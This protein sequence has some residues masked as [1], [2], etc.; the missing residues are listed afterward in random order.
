M[1]L[2][3]V[4][5]CSAPATWGR[6]MPRGW[7]RRASMY[8]GWK[9]TRG[10]GG[11]SAGGGRPAEGGA[12]RPRGSPLPRAGTRAAAALRPEV[13]TAFLHHVLRGGGRLRRPAL[14]LRGHAAA[15]GLL[16]RR[17]L[18]GEWLPAR[19]RNA[20]GPAVPSRR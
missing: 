7:P 8:S 19:A 3:A 12:A 18:P 9:P 13:W 10:R 2:C 17:P 4:L 14:H 1:A 20:A 16:L 5:P 15:G 6:Y 11:G